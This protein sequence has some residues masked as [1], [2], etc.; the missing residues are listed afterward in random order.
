MTSGTSPVKNGKN[1]LEDATASFKEKRLQEKKNNLKIEMVVLFS[2]LVIL[3]LVLAT[4]ATIGINSA[5]LHKVWSVLTAPQPFTIGQLTLGGVAFIGV[6]GVVEIIR[7]K[8]NSQS[9]NDSLLSPNQLE[10]PMASVVNYDRKA[11]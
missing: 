3:G 10:G 6:L 5:G 8:R 11:G 4:H 2:S 1:L 9:Q 7:C